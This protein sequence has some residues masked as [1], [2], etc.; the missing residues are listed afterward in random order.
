MVRLQ[1][2]IERDGESRQQRHADKYPTTQRHRPILLPRETFSIA[3]FYDRKRTTR[4]AP[5]SEGAAEDHSDWWRVSF[6]S[7]SASSVS[8][9]IAARYIPT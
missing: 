7:S 8:P 5:R 3:R 6:I 4:A 9:A 2:V 1:P